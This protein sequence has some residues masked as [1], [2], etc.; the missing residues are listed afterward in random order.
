MNLILV[1]LRLYFVDFAI[2]E[3]FSDCPN[4][5]SEPVVKPLTHGD[6]GDY[7]MLYTTVAKTRVR[8]SVS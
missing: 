6:V 7:K 5:C 3:N 8:L 2:P 1:Y 4:S